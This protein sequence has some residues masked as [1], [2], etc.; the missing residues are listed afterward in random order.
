MSRTDN[1]VPYKYRRTASERAKA[2]KS[3]AMGREKK[4]RQAAWWHAVRASQ[5]TALAVHR[6]P[7]PA[8]HRRQA[9]WDCW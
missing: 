9:T 3:K 4:A 7:P 2:W 5:R 8:R 6:E 1:T